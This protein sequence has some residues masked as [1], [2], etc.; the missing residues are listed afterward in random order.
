MSGSGDSSYGSNSGNINYISSTVGCCR[1]RS[2]G[3]TFSGFSGS[4]RFSG[5]NGF[6]THQASTPLTM[7]TTIMP[8]QATPNTVPTTLSSAHARP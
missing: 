5:F 6:S 4:N 7:P 2:T 1:S 3:L 8:S